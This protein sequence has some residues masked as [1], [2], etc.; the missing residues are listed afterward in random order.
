M[1]FC[2][3]IGSFILGIIIGFVLVFGGVGLAGYLVLTKEGMVG[4]IADKVEAFNPAEEIAEKSLLEYGQT[5]FD[6]ISKFSDTTFGVLEDTIGIN[7]TNTLAEALGLETSVLRDSTVGNVAD[8]I[9]NGYTITSL[10][11][12]FG[13][14]LPDLPMFQDEE[15]RNKPIK[16]AFTYLSEQLNFDT[17]TVR[18]LNTK[19]GVTLGDMLGKPEFLDTPI[20]QLGDKISASPLHTFVSITLNVE[21][22]RYEAEHVATATTLTEWK[23]GKTA[24]VPAEDGSNYGTD[25]S[26]VFDNPEGFFTTTLYFDNVVDGEG[27]VVKTAREVQAEWIAAYNAIEGNEPVVEFWQYAIENKDLY[28][29]VMANNLDDIKAWTSTQWKANR[30]YVDSTAFEAWYA[31]NNVEGNDVY[32]KSLVEAKDAYYASIWAVPE[33]NSDMA[34]WQANNADGTMAQY[35]DYLFNGVYGATVNYYDYMPSLVAPI[36]PSVVVTETEGKDEATINK[37]YVATIPVASNKTLQ[38]L[39]YAVVGSNGSDGLNAYMNNM[40]LDDA[41]DIK[42]T[43]HAL[44]Q[45]IKY[46][47]IANIGSA[48][49]NEVNNMALRE[50]MTI[51]TD[52]EAN[53]L[54]GN[55]V[56][57]EEERQALIDDWGADN[58]FETKAE[59][60]AWIEE[61]AGQGNV[62]YD[63]LAWERDMAIAGK[64]WF[65]T[66]TDRAT[67]YAKYLEANST[68]PAYDTLSPEQKDAFGIVIDGNINFAKPYAPEVVPGY[69]KATP[70]N[71][72]LQ[73]IASSTPTTLNGDISNLTLI[74]IFGEKE[75]G[76]M[77]LISGY[78]KLDNISTAMTTAIQDS[79]MQQLFD[80]K[81]LTEKTAYNPNGMIDL[82]RLNDTNREMLLGCNIIQL[83]EKYVAALAA[84]QTP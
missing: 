32:G 57:A 39:Y 5:V 2:A 33:A 67:E 73:A 72:M 77:S 35:I 1:K 7:I 26:F 47:K 68:E 29:A 8:N 27:K 65:G 81:I 10:Q 36:A 9:L 40:T 15:F 82:S 83:V 23:N 4:T 60:Q 22:D 53:Y 34:I 55:T 69:V 75:E 84:T 42:D 3:K 28:D 50:L 6:T 12:K 64:K 11:D 59:Q 20:N 37:E 79:T 38:Y 74:D 24:F 80:A 30:D 61:Q 56:A 31:I 46:E 49:T 71:K 62:Y 58:Y 45:R 76:A 16:D 66:E 41:T 18:E 43:D 70:S 19:F 63:R 14:T 25:S 51:V 78:T 44:L 48:V 13:I 52:A 17:M 54:N 21:V